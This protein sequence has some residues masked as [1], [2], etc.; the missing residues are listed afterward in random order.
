MKTSDI[1]VMCLFFF[2]LIFFF[3]HAKSKKVKIFYFFLVIILMFFF[4][5][6]LMFFF[7]FFFDCLD[8]FFLTDLQIE[9]F[10]SCNVSSKV[11]ENYNSLKDIMQSYFQKTKNN[12]YRGRNLEEY[13]TNKVWWHLFILNVIGAK[14][15]SGSL[16][17]TVFDMIDMEIA[18]ENKK[19]LFSSYYQYWFPNS[20]LNLGLSLYI[21]FL[22]GLLKCSLSIIVDYFWIPFFSLVSFVLNV[23]YSFGSSILTFF[24]SFPANLI[25]PSGSWD[26]PFSNLIIGFYN[27]QGI[28][29]WF[30]EMQEAYSLGKYHVC[31]F[32]TIWWIFVLHVRFS[33]FNNRPDGL[34]LL[35]IYLSFIAPF[36]PFSF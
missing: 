28:F 22:L 27:F 35:V 6:F 36:L 24:I 34:W 2:F 29:T 33:A 23:F 31:F 32:N 1:L 12:M 7:I 5:F 30:S 18:A 19:V 15:A 17:F 4:I 14:S 26:N 3:F 21:T 20:K 8:F 10:S 11:S 13:K 9:G 16:P 25:K